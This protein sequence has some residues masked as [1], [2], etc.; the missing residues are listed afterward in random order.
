MEVFVK[1]EFCCIIDATE[2]VEI[3]MVKPEPSLVF[4]QKGKR[5][6]RDGDR[7]IDSEA[8]GHS[9][10]KLGLTAAELSGEGDKAPRLQQASEPLPQQDGI[11]NTVRT[12]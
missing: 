3:E 8:G 1:T 5:G 7:A 4:I 6:T 9:P 12:K 2:P 11:F 10:D